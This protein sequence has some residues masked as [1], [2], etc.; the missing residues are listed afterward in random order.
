[1]SKGGGEM[2]VKAL[3]FEKKMRRMIKE[4]QKENGQKITEKN[5][6]KTS[7]NKEKKGEEKT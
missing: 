5:K 4:D 3:C 6:V 1:M 7:K 2:K